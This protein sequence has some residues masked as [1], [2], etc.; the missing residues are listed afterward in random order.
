MVSGA[1]GLWGKEKGTREGEILEVELEETK[2]EGIYILEVLL[3]H[4]RGFVP[5]DVV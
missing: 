4:M 3:H 5:E 2:K 1:Y